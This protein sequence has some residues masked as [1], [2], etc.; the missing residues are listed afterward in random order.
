MTN[1]IKQYI[2]AMVETNEA[3]TVMPFDTPEELSAIPFVAA[4]TAMPNFHRFSVSPRIGARALLIAEY[5]GGAEWW[6]V[7]Y[8]EQPVSE[9][10]MWDADEATALRKAREKRQQ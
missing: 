4:F 3:P 2:P 8:L 10:P 6:V 7:G 5:H 9:L 1:S